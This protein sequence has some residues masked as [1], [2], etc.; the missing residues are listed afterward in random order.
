MDEVELGP[1]VAECLVD[2]PAERVRLGEPGRAHDPELL[3]V[4]ERPV[5]VRPRHAERVLAFVEIEAVYFF[6]HDR[7]VGDRPWP[8]REHRDLVP[9]FGEFARQ[10][11]AVDTLPAAMRVPPVDQ[12][13]DPKRITRAQNA[14]RC[15][16]R[17]EE[18]R[19]EAG[20]ARGQA[21]WS[22]ERR[23]RESSKRGEK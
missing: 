19:M 9:E 2:A 17:H 10:V 8:A 15:C 5:L 22:R 14:G 11:A 4:D 13:R 16:S 7:V 18:T 21:R 6:E 20:G 23:P 1:A 12:E 3:E